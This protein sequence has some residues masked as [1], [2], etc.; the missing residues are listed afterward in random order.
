MTAVPNVRLN[1]PNTLGSVSLVHEALIGLAA[2]LALDPL[3]TNDLDTAVTEICKNVVYHAYEGADGPLEVRVHVLAG[4]LEVVVRDRGIGIRPHVG[5]RT[6]PHS[7]IG[8]PIVH[9]LTQSITFSK[10]DGGGTEVRML[11]AAHDAAELEPL[12]PGELQSP[13]A[14]DFEPAHRI[15][16]ALAPDSVA[17][18]ILPRVLGAL[19]A[20]ADLSDDRASDVR[21]LARAL[22]AGAGNSTA[23]AH[24]A[25]AATVAPGSLELR[26]GPL[27]AGG[28][29]ALLKAGAGGGGG[30]RPLE[31]LADDHRVSAAGSAELLELRV[32]ERP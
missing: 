30:E 8:L 12:G 4:A 5:E 26:V 28:A 7:G 2:R 17:E 23:G 25:V 13:A 9:A 18:A 6:Q 29:R 1:L 10:R 20:Q 16:I 27:R 31:S 32:S 15:A 21:L 19:A 11:F 22:A 3:E 24:L 14:E